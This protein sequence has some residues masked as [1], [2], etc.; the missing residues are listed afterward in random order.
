MISKEGID[1][2]F[3]KNVN[4]QFHQ[5]NNCITTI[6]PIHHLMDLDVG[7]CVLFL[8]EFNSLIEHLRTS[9]TLN[10]NRCDSCMAL[11]RLLNEY[12]QVMCADAD[13]PDKSLG[14]LKKFCG[15][16]FQ[17]VKKCAQAQQQCEGDGNIQLHGAAE[18]TEG[19]GQATWCP[20]IRTRRPTNCTATCE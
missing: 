12:Q 9:T 2:R 10:N 15:K 19:D 18:L 3:C 8:G 13:A 1:T 4:N 7:K 6:E 5:G 20:A 17:C 11:A 16:K 14:F